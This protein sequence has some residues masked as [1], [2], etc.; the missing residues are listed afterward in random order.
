MNQPFL[1]E[2]GWVLVE[3]TPRFQ[4]EPLEAV[5]HVV[6]CDDYEEHAISFKCWCQPYLDHK[7]HETGTEIVIHRRAIDLRQ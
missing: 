5:L 4:E 1:N 7:E 6:P 2:T 3:E